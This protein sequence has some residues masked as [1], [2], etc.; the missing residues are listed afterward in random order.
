MQTTIQFNN[1]STFQEWS[2]FKFK[3][4]N[5][6]AEQTPL[7]NKKSDVDVLLIHL[8]KQLSKEEIS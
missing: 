2:N 7:L 5:L 8:S 4:N 6:K 3:L 1:P